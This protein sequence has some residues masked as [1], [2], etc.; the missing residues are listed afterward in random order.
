MAVAEFVVACGD[1]MGV[2]KETPKSRNWKSLSKTTVPIVLRRNSSYDDMIASV[3]KADELTCE[4]NDLREQE[5]GLQSNHSFSDRT[6]LCINQSFSNKNELQLLLAK[7]VAKKTFDFAIVKSCTK[8]LMNKFPAAIVILEH[9]IGF[10]KWS[11]AHFP[12]NRYDVMTKNIT[13]S[14]NAMLINEREYPMA[15]ICNSISKRF[16]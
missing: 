8:Y 12:G 11:K 9:D 10:K 7:A 14:L 3:I 16:G 2:W 13:K 4:P 15:S 5:M 1:Y 6:N